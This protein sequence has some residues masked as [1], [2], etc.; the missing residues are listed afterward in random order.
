MWIAASVYHSLL[1]FYLPCFM[2]K[3]GKG[4]I[5]QILVSDFKLTFINKRSS[6]VF[7]FKFS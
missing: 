6:V 7:I 5:P 1:L 3:H 4:F 2:L